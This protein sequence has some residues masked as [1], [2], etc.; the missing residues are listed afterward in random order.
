[1]FSWSYGIFNESDHPII[2][3]LDLSE[4]KNLMYSTKGAVAKTTAEPRECSF[5]LHAQAGFG[6]FSKVIKHEVEHLPKKKWKV[7][8]C[9]QSNLKILLF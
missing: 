6:E 1:M 3:K 4:S 8:G 7:K 9:N 5:L 2:T